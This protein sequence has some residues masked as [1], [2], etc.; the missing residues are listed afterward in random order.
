MINIYRLCCGLNSAAS[1]Y[2]LYLKW[3]VV[4]VYHTPLRDGSNFDHQN[5]DFFKQIKIIIYRLTVL[6]V[7]KKQTILLLFRQLYLI[8]MY[9]ISTKICKKCCT[10]D[11][12]NYVCLWP[13]LVLYI[14]KKYVCYLSKNGQIIAEK[15]IADL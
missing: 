14:L 4:G 13:I 2:R 15:H 1:F 3:C 9:V 8:S 6:T 11:T 12:T 10:I 7:L 5:I